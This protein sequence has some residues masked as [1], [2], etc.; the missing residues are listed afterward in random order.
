MYDQI[1]IDCQTQKE[2]VSC[3]D[4]IVG[5]SCHLRLELGE[6]TRTVEEAESAQSLLVPLLLMRV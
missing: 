3:G 1:V 5:E 6:K 2:S 4:C